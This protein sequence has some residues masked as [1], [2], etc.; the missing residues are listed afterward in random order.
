MANARHV[1]IDACGKYIGLS[2]VES[3]GEY[4]Q[5]F[6]YTQ[7]FITN[8]IVFLSFINESDVINLHKIFTKCS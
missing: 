5:P 2:R 6:V 4:Y 3:P 1:E 7:C 8:G